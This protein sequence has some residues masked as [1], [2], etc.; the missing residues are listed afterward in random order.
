[1]TDGASRHSGVAVEHRGGNRIY[2][3]LLNPK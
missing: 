1:V 3:D 2:G